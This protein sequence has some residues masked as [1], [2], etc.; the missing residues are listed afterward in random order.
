M[1]ASITVLSLSFLLG[2]FQSCGPIPDKE[3]PCCTKP[4]IPTDPTF[5]PYRAEFEYYSKA[6]TD[7]IPM[8]FA[9]LKETTVGLCHYF[10][11]GSGPI[12]WGYIEIDR[13][14]WNRASKYQKINLIFHELGHCVLGRDH[15]PWGNS[16]MACPSSLMYDSILSTECIENNYYNYI[17]ELFPLWDK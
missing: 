14:F 1:K 11:V 16:M 17:E 2:F 15:A 10:R 13:S 4:M 6:N 7:L 8:Y 5:E 3:F 9:D 12:R